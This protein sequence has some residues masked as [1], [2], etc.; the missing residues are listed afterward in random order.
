MR[1]IGVNKSVFR[2]KAV[3][4]KEEEGASGY[5]EKPRGECSSVTKKEGTTYQPRRHVLTP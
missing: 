4:N 1:V 2:K 5:R 3:G